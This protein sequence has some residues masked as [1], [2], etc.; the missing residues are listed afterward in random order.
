MDQ[1]AEKAEFLS[2][3]AS[4]LPDFF[5]CSCAVEGEEVLHAARFRKQVCGMA[6]LRG[7]D[8]DCFD[9]IKNVFVSKEVEVSGA[10]GKLLVIE[11]VVV[12]P[13]SDLG[14]I[15]IRRQPEFRE[16]LFQVSLF[17]WFALDSGTY[18]LESLG[19][20][21]QSL[22]DVPRGSDVVVYRWR[23]GNEIGRAS[24]RETIYI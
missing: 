11:R 12:R 20:L 8:C 22:V 18:S 2:D 13:P 16:A 24:W 17:D 23:K 14:H 4:I 3:V 6:Q 9:Q 5:L 10:L 21:S 1:P 7:F 19:V 15:E